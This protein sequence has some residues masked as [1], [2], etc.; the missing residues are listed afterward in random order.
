MINNKGA[1][2]TVNESLICNFIVLK[3]TE[4]INYSKNCKNNVDKNCIEL[5][6]TPMKHTKNV[7]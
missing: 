5:P 2:M 7:S 6:P 3:P 1:F 4:K